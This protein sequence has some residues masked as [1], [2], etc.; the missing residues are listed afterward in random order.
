MEIYVTC[1]LEVM[2]WFR[3]RYENKVICHIKIVSE[4]LSLYYVSKMHCNLKL[5][6]LHM[7]V[8]TLSFNGCWIFFL[9]DHTVNKHTFKISRICLNGCSS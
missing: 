5:K 2:K 1:I 7:C 3:L 9:H 4:S 8:Y 6:G